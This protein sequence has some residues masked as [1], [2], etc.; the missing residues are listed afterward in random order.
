MLGSR[1]CYRSKPWNN[2]RC[3]SLPHGNLEHF[4]CSNRNFRAA[5]TERHQSLHRK[6]QALISPI[7]RSLCSDF[8]SRSAPRYLGMLFYQNHQIHPQ[9]SLT[10][11]H[12]PE[13]LAGS[14]AV[15]YVCG[16][17]AIADVSTSPRYRLEDFFEKLKPRLQAKIRHVLIAEHDL[18]LP[19]KVI[20]YIANNMSI[21]RLT[22]GLG[23]EFT[24]LIRSRARLPSYHLVTW[25][26]T[27]WQRSNALSWTLR[28][29]TARPTLFRFGNGF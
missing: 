23:L 17:F 15:L 12:M 29:R 19:E 10:L 14:E 28:M 20:I 6:P 5:A 18:R 11:L 1:H 7:L 22:I 9:R 27:H 26:A 3:Q 16:I 2:S 13:M 25:R 8:L 24:E 21:D 4:L